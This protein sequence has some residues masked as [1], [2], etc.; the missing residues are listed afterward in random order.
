VSF[1]LSEALEAARP[2]PVPLQ[3]HTGF[4][5][6]DLT[7]HRADPTLLRP[8]FEDSRNRDVPIILLHCYPFVRQA[9]YLASVYSNAYL[10]LSLAMTF[11]AHRGSDLVLEALELAPASKLLFA[12]DAS[13]L[14]ELF[15]LG[16]RSWRR[17]LAGA[18]G[19]LMEGS[20]VDQRT[21]VR[22]AELILRGN[23]RRL[24]G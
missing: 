9:S 19:T 17:S 2:R 22:W 11:A 13:R 24:Y 7:L 1:F 10:D 21:A 14:P 5:D 15:F 3:V 12:T 18:L 4:G 20:L 8:L 16:A 23:A 6:T